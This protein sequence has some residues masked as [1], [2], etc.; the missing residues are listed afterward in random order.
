VITPVPATGGGVDGPV[1]A[2][3]I[4]PLSVSIAFK[5]PAGTDRKIPVSVTKNGKKVSSA[6]SRKKDIITVRVA[7]PEGSHAITVTAGRRNEARPV[8]TGAIETGRRAEGTVPARPAPPAASESGRLP[9]PAPAAEAAV[10]PNLY[11]LTIGVSKLKYPTD[12]LPNL[13]FAAA[14]AVAVRESLETQQG[15]VFDEVRTWELL[16]ENGTLENVRKAIAEL[17]AAIQARGRRTAPDGSMIRDVTVIFLAGHGVQTTDGEFYFLTHDF[18]FARRNDTGLRFIELGDSVTSF[19][20]ELFILIDACHSSMAGATALS[21][22]R[23]EELFKR[24][25][26]LNERAQT[27]F[28]AS[29]K[30]EL[31]LEDPNLGHGLFT[32]GILKTLQTA[33]PNMDIS[34]LQL[35]DMTMKKVLEWSSRQQK[36]SYR[37]YGD[38]SRW[39]V[40]RR[41]DPLPEKR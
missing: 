34:V 19:P 11:V 41:L 2:S 1:D 37:V 10:K 4:R 29:Q 38:Q 26:A 20:T 31:A 5:V 9:A 16:N 32:N 30:G 40:Y 7:A 14:D 3:P 6:V 22:L 21:G 17:E 25:S 27:I 28:S 24:L 12:S 23:P 33:P 35:I 8:F 18:D 15:V 13:K 36:P 39:I